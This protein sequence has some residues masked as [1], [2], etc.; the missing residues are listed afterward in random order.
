MGSIEVPGYFI[1][2]KTDSFVSYIH[3]ELLYEHYGGKKHL[4]FIDQDHN[5]SRKEDELRE[6]FQ[7]V[8][9]IFQRVEGS[10]HSKCNNI[11]LNNLRHQVKEKHRSSST[12][13][14]FRL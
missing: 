11:L 14:S 4:Q 2:S 13:A 7:F 3:S 12:K 1:A 6:I 5:Q 9:R 10:A 8:K